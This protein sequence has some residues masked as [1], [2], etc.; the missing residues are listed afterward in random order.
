MSSPCYGECYS[1][2]LLRWELIIKNACSI[3]TT[4]TFISCNKKEGSGRTII[5]SIKKRSGH[6]SRCRGLL[7]LY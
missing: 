1:E 7:Q 5:R 6:L 2:L 3:N 4:L